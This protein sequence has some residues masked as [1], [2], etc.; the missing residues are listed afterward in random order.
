MGETADR[1]RCGRASP[2][3]KC[4]AITLPFYSFSFETTK[5][6]AGCRALNRNYI[7]AGKRYVKEE[8]EMGGNSGF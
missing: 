1:F 4:Q 8:N 7:V 3:G 6:T 5:G 2:R